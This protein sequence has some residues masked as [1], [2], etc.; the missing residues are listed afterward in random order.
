MPDMTSLKQLEMRTSQMQ[1][2]QTV[3]NQQRTV[4]IAH[5]P[6]G[7]E[8]ARHSGDTSQCLSEQKACQSMSPNCR[9]T[10]TY[11]SN[12]WFGNKRTN[13]IGAD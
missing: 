8:V 6:H 2:A 13:R 11:R 7:L 9:T 5:P 1:R 10:K 3:Q 4:F 12:N